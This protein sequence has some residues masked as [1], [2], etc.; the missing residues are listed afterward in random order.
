[1]A[2][3]TIP[4]GNLY[5]NN[6]LWTGNN[7]AR[8]ITGVGFQPDFTWIKSR[9]QAYN[10][11]LTDVL[12]GT[13]KYLSSNT[14][15]GETTDAQTLTAF[16]SD[17]FS[18][19][20]SNLVNQN[21]QDHVA[22]NWK[23][24]TGQGSSNTDGSINTAYT[25]V[26]TTAGF[27]ISSFT[28]TGANATFGHGLGAVPK[29]YILK[30]Y[31]SSNNWRVYHESIGNGKYMTLETTEAEQTSSGFTNN[32]SPTSSLISL[33]NLGSA[34]PSGGSVICYAFA[35]KQGYSKFGSYTGN[36]NADGTFVYTGFLPSFVM[37]KQ[38]N[39][40]G[41]DW[42]ICDNKR[43]GYNGEN[44]RL[45]PNLNSAESTDSP[46]DILSNG[47]KARQSGA[48]VN[49]SGASYIYMAFAENPFVATSGTNAIPVTAR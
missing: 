31:D 40:S 12:R 9:T 34:N 10:H 18:I 35:E 39:A 45:L 20:T 41:E 23:A 17:G 28:G 8:T 1:M 7:T 33:G 29:M 6:V 43:E 4:K 25:S 2:Y 46:I 16:A 26:N 48:A 42:F 36:G 37:V 15:T 14:T 38:T 22:W 21:V 32:T 47:F 27:S 5:M 30:R 49:G 13:T 44:N 19:G 3:S 24:G 11:I